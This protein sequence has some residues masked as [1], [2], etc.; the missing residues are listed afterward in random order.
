MSCGEVFLSQEQ[1]VAVRSDCCRSSCWVLLKSWPEAVGSREQVTDIPLMPTVGA[2]GKA[3]NTN[4]ES[5]VSEVLA[6]LMAGHQVLHTP[7][8]A[9]S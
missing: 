2:G 9:E 3:E 5:A 4:K 8:A 7:L 6:R 1:L